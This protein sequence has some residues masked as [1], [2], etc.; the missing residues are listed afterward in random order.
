MNDFFVFVLCGF[1]GSIVGRYRFSVEPIGEIIFSK[2]YLVRMFWLVPRIEFC[3]LV[4]IVQGI[5]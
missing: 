1:H 3:C 2:L 4:F 5:F